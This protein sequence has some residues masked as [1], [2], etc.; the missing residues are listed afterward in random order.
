MGNIAME[1][2]TKGLMG[3][4]ARFIKQELKDETYKHR[5]WKIQPLQ[6]MKARTVFAQSNSTS[7][8]IACIEGVVSAEKFR[9]NEASTPPE[10]Q[11]GQAR[12]VLTKGRILTQE[13][14]PKGWQL[15]V[16]LDDNTIELPFPYY[17]IWEKPFVFRKRDKELEMDLFW[18]YEAKQGSGLIPDYGDKP[19]KIIKAEDDI[20][21]DEVY[22]WK[23]DCS[24]KYYIPGTQIEKQD[25][26]LERL[27][28]YNPEEDA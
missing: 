8:R 14:V 22:L 28:E 15:L 20:M 1:I 3:L 10:K 21:Y 27:S 2:A 11:I 17:S 16:A 23:L 19:I 5:P 18:F 6:Y 13:E 24:R 25:D 7:V 12:F 9:I 26:I 4:A